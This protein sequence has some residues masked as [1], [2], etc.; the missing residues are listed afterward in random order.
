M[1]NAPGATLCARRSL[2]HWEEPCLLTIHQIPL[3]CLSISI[4]GRKIPRSIPT[5]TAKQQSQE[6]PTMLAIPCYHAAVR[7]AVDEAECGIYLDTFDTSSRTVW[8][9]QGCGLNY[10]SECWTRW[11]V[12]EC[13]LEDGRTGCVYCTIPW[14]DCSICDDSYSTVYWSR[15]HVAAHKHLLETASLSF[16]I[17]YMRLSYCLRC[18]ILMIAAVLTGVCSILWFLEVAGF[19]DVNPELLRLAVVRYVIWK[20]LC[21]AAGVSHALIA[22]VCIV[23]I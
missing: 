19:F 4:Y 23:L 7:K 12:R 17:S 10:H 18:I 20:I 5:T 2:P 22:W 9:K 13:S 14:E 6:F 21:L 16:A 8:C 15:G 11:V 1:H 3:P